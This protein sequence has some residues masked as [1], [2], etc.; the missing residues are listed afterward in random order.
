MLHSWLDLPIEV[1]TLGPNIVK[2]I[3]AFAL[4]RAPRSLLFPST[5]CEKLDG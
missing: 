4:A 5:H 3:T 2:A 1:L